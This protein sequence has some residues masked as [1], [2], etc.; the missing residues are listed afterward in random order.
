VPL[1]SLYSASRFAV[2]CLSFRCTVPLVSLYSASRIVKQFL[3]AIKKFRKENISLASLC[4]SVRLSLCTEQL[5]CHW[6]D[7]H[8]I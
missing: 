2:Q 7:F 8:E 4:L 5:G 1:V 3:G 6:T